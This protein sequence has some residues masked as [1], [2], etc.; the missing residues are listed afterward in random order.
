MAQPAKRPAALPDIILSLLHKSA[1]GV[2]TLAPGIAARILEELNFP[3]QR[4]RKTFRVGEHQARIQKG[5][6]NPEY[7]ITLLQMPDGAMWLAD[8]QHRMEAIAQSGTAIAVRINLM[9]AAN[10]HEARRIYA[11]FDR[12]EYIRTQEE[13]L[14]GLGMTTATGLKQRTVRSLFRALPILL[15]NMEHARSNQ[16]HAAAA[17]SVEARI[18]LLP[19]WTPEA[20]RYEA[21][22]DSAEPALKTP[23]YGA[24]VMSVA[25][26]VMRYQPTRAEEFWLGVI[27]GGMLNK[28]DPRQRLMWDLLNR[29]LNAGSI[30]QGIQMTALA[31]TRW[32]EG[33][34]MKM[35]RCTEGAPII[36][37]GTPL[38]KGNRS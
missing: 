18:D 1:D 30:R 26:Y 34:R 8:G 14:A 2:I 33:A 7:P 24:G 37:W 19:E 11:G 5:R 21:I 35:I 15:N 13:M 22:F 10:E 9:R 29:N 28:D 31:W 25:L 27:D 36:I 20:A 23:L 12:P 3:G 6:W 32:C 38:A 17:R 16:E 4:K